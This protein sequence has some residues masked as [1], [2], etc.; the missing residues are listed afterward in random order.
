VILAVALS[1]F[2]PPAPAGRPPALSGDRLEAARRDWRNVS[3]GQLSAAAFKTRYGLTNGSMT[4]L[5]Q[6]YPKDFGKLDPSL[7]ERQFSAA[8]LGRM[9][10]DWRRVGAGEI[11]AKHETSKKE[12][13]ELRQQP[14]GAGRFARAHHS[15]A[16][17]I[18][19]RRRK[20]TLSGAQVSELSRLWNASVVP[21]TVSIDEFKKA[22]RL[23][24]RGYRE[25]RG[26]KAAFPDPEKIKHA[27]GPE[28]R[29]FTA[30]E[31]AAIKADWQRVLHLDL[32]RDAFLKKHNLHSEMMKRLRDAHPDDFPSLSG[33]TRKIQFGGR[34]LEAMRDDWLLV[35]AGR[36]R[37][38]DFRAEHQLSTTL[39]KRLR[40]EGDLAADFPKTK[41]GTPQTAAIDR[42]VVGDWAEVRG[43]RLGAGEFRRRHPRVRAAELLGLQELARGVGRRSLAEELGLVKPEPPKLVKV[44]APPKPTPEPKPRPERK[45]QSP[46]LYGE[47]QLA[48]ARTLFARH[49]RGELELQRDVAPALRRI[50]ITATGPGLA[51]LRKLDPLAFAGR[52]EFLSCNHASI[53]TDLIGI[54]RASRHVVR[55]WS[56]LAE[57]VGKDT[58]FVARWGQLKINPM[59]GVVQ[60]DRD[61]DGRLRD[62][63]AAIGTQVGKGSGGRAIRSAKAAEGQPAMVVAPRQESAR[64]LAQALRG[65]ERTPANLEMVTA[66]LAQ[67]DPNFATR[68]RWM[69][70]RAEFEG[71][72]PELARWNFDP[73]RP[74]SVRY[75]A[76]WTEAAHQAGAGAGYEEIVALFKRSIEYQEDGRLPPKASGT[77]IMARLHPEL[78]SSWANRRTYQR[79][80]Q[81][82][83][84][85]RAAPKGATLY[86][87]AD[88]VRA[89]GLPQRNAYKWLS[90]LGAA[91]GEHYGMSRNTFEELKRSGFHGLGQARN[92]GFD[93]NAELPGVRLDLVR[94]ILDT[95]RMP[96]LLELA[97]SRLDGRRPFEAHNVMF[98]NHRYSDIVSLVDAMARAGMQRENAVFVST[99]YPF[100]DAVTCQLE[101]SGVR[102][103]V[104]KQD[105]ASYANAVEQGIQRMLELHQQQKQKWGKGKPI[106]ILDD[107]GMASKLI[108]SKFKEH[109]SKFRIVEVTAAG[110][111]LAQGFQEQHKR[112]PFVYYSIAHTELK[113]RITSSFFGRRVAQR[114]LNLVPQTGVKLLN[115]RVAIL[116]GGPMGLFAGLELRQQGYEVTFVDPDP[117]VAARLRD[118]Y[119]FPVTTIEQALPGRGLVV[120][121]SGYQTVRKEHLGLIEDGAVLA[122]G[123]S[124]RN[125][126]DMDAFEG[127]AS[128]KLL[129]RE[130]GLSQKSYT[131]S[132]RGGKKLHFLGDGW[133]INHDGSLHGTP[134]RDIQLELAIYFESAVQAASTPL[135]QTGVF[136]EIGK[137]LQSY[138]LS[139]W[140][141]VRRAK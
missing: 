28:R 6:I 81:L 105:M 88:Q 131:Y 79:T 86:S 103:I 47:S 92:P 16:T 139:E 80:R 98:I 76:R 56:D 115:R 91:D 141:K 122:Q 24:Q 73:H 126:F 62:A 34:Q 67:S 12:I 99:P 135:G 17:G 51:Y 65:L 22:Q 18:A 64:A 111:R 84:L 43:G 83:E 49:Q 45:Y 29:T 119:K 14:E 11:Y 100:K 107:G 48:E 101:K 36:K 96:R 97:I 75:V 90:K 57:V 68:R 44:A 38:V 74:Y 134:M 110:V 137:D 70:V 125:E 54:A 15:S 133:T 127:L 20:E 112:L 32:D 31:L 78:I 61:G 121:M 59:T 140:R 109:A 95:P 27:G 58:A 40:S 21:G 89:I 71:V 72:F 50:G 30:A 46:S 93:R 82:L 104:P 94:D 113:Q 108:A 3:A 19:S 9:A 120:G 129:P 132:F 13:T 138:Y 4:R 106:L 130:D 60:R 117:A 66:R 25:L 42:A 118:K 41:G 2:A 1:L 114:V 5:R 10:Q 85:L 128:K 23:T 116:G 7:R 123:S 8:D 55:K 37:E 102:T 39:F 53:V 26:D 136:R 35:I 69:S 52:E 77:V 33:Q 87:L 63:M 124:K